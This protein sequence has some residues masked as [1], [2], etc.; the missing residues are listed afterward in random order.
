MVLMFNGGKRHHFNQLRFLVHCCVF[1]VDLLK[2][3]RLPLPVEVV[4]LYATSVVLI[5][6]IGLNPN[7]TARKEVLYFYFRW[8]PNSQM[9][10]VDSTSTEDRRRWGER[11]CAW[12]FLRSAQSV[13][14][15][16][17]YVVASISVCDL[18]LQLLSGCLRWRVPVA[19]EHSVSARYWRKQVWRNYSQRSVDFD[20]GS[21]FPRI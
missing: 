8:F 21:L 15:S 17:K 12:N 3:A 18:Y 2:I 13:I 7:T 16:M 19:S 11:I 9:R 1:C 20:C 4:W 6:K 14:R 10:K 5:D